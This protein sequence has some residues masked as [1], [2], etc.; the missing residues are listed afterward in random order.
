MDDIFS[1]PINMIKT[2]IKSSG[3]AIQN[4]YIQH[5]QFHSSNPNDIR[6]YFSVNDPDYIPSDSPSESSD[7]PN[8]PDWPGGL[9]SE[10]LS[11]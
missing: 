10:E 3:P 1:K 6:H 4:S 5:T 8:D 7:P 2:W 11:E 9:E